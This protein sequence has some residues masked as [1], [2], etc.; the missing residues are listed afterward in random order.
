MY[1]AKLYVEEEKALEAMKFMIKN[2]IAIENPTECSKYFHDTNLAIAH[3]FYNRTYPKHLENFRNSIV[4][5][6]NH[7][8]FSFSNLQLACVVSRTYSISGKIEDLE[9]AYDYEK[10][11]RMIWIKQMKHYCALKSF[12]TP[13]YAKGRCGGDCFL[14]FN[15]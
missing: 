3:E 8:T 4:A 12:L 15:R 10:R 14:I 2:D 1:I 5:L 9:R 6:G 11:L 13:K 7:T